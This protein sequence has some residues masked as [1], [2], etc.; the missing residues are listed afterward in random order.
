[1]KHDPGAFPCVFASPV[2]ASNCADL[3]HNDISYSTCQVNV[4]RDQIA[5]F[6]YNNNGQP[7]GQFANLIEDLSDK[8][9]EVLFAMNAGMFHSDLR[10][11]GHYIE[12]SQEEMP[13]VSNAGPGNFGMLPNGIF[14]ITDSHYHIFETHDYLGKKPNCTYATQSGPS[15]FTKTSFIRAS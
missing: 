14:C 15:C 4:D 10:P 13:V 11:V 2:L 9:T 8:G 5:L 1:M 6:L 3:T 7:Y 12:N